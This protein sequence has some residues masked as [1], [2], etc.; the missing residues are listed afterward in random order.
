MCNKE[1]TT[2][3]EQQPTSTSTFIGRPRKLD[4][5]T[6][7]LTQ[8]QIYY[9]RARDKQDAKPTHDAKYLSIDDPN[10]TQ[11]QKKSLKYRTDNPDKIKNSN[12]IWKHNN[13]D[14]VREYN[15]RY[16]AEN[17]K[18]IRAPMFIPASE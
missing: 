1:T 14:R 13:K 16:A 6:P 3:M 12:N 15:R 10:L 18:R 11:S 2:N 9:L 17:R 8:Y 5:S 4:W 7:G